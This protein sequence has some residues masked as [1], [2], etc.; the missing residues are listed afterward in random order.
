MYLV[1]LLAAAAII[2]G[3]VVVAMGRGGELAL[4]PRDLPLTATEL[5]TPADVALVRLP[6][7]PLG[8]QVQATTEAL[9]CAARLLAEREAELSALRGELRQFRPDDFRPDDFRPDDHRPDDHR[10]DDDEE[11]PSEI[12]A[13]E[14]D[15]FHPANLDQQQGL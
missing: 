5:R 7:A 4:V 11:G 9:A 15:E 3:V 8:F 13:D 10:P 2:A 1:L 14:I 6:L 12:D